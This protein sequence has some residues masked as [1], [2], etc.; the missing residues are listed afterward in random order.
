MSCAIKK[1]ISVIRAGTP[2]QLADS[3]TE[4]QSRETTNVF[5]S[6]TH[7]DPVNGAWL[8]FVFENKRLEG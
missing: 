3:L 8:A 6:Q 5:A 4:Y 1:E 2:E 7:F